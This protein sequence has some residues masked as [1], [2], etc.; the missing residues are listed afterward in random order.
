MN[1][2]LI[3]NFFKNPD[4]V[5]QFALSKSNQY[6]KSSEKTGWKGY[7]TSVDNIE[8]MDYIKNKLIDI[9]DKFINF[10][11]DECYFHYSLETTKNELNNNFEKKRLHKDSSELA[12]V[13]YLT[14]NPIKNSGTTLHND[15]TDLEDVIDNVY[16][17]FVLYNGK[18]LHGP[19]DTF[20]DSIEN[21]RFTLTIFGDI[22]KSKKSII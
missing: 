2:I 3:D 19:Q 20:G 7:R 15:N 6:A 11:I 12:G 1:Y 18:K 14:P 21:A 16:N 8:L 13:I 4:V 5:R 22:L 9:D 17:R 10:V